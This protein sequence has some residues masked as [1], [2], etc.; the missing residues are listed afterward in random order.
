MSDEI[1]AEMDDYSSVGKQ[2][3][4]DGGQG[5]LFWPQHRYPEVWPQAA[6]TMYSFLSI[7]QERMIKKRLNNN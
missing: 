2:F 3:D 6:L 1:K 5:E 4:Y 7:N